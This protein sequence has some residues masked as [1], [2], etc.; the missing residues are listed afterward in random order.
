[1]T[2]WTGARRRPARTR[3]SLPASGRAIVILDSTSRTDR[4]E[5]PGVH[6]A[7][8]VPS[9]HAAQA[10]GVTNRPKRARRRR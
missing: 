3:T 5:S 7:L 1:M 6:L 2:L 8:R 9:R 10:A 4:P